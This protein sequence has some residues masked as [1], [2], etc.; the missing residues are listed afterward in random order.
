MYVGIP[1]NQSCPMTPVSKETAV[2]TFDNVSVGIKFFSRF[3]REI[4]RSGGREQMIRQVKAS[5]TYSSLSVSKTRMK[6]AREK[7]YY[8]TARQN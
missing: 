4:A 8:V 7:K 5:S 1:E 3:L 2:V 6:R